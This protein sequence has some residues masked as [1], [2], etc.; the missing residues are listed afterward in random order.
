MHSSPISA[1]GSAS[2]LDI[3]RRNL[4]A[5]AACAAALAAPEAYA[6]TS[7]NAVYLLVHGAWHG[8]W[9]WKKIVPLLRA[10]GHEVYTPTLT[11]L[12]ERSHLAHRDVGLE[13]HIL[14]IVN[15]LQ[16]EDLREVILVGH[17]SGGIVI[18]GVA[19]RVPERL[20]HVVYLDAFVPEDGQALMDIIPADRR[21]GIERRVQAEGGGWQLPSLSPTPWDTFL[22]DAWAIDN[23]ADRQWMLPRLRPMPF[24]TFTDKVR[25]SNP[26][27]EKLPRSFIRC[28]QWP[29]P[30]FDRYADSAR[31]TAGWRYREI[32]AS[33][34]PFV[35]HPQDLAN[36]LLDIAG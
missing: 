13:T 26:V 11:G 36:V 16:Y 17:S 1:M 19:D 3:S 4:L 21:E 29:H 5:A 34:E 22:R 33:H 35:T 9:C 2:H 25:R 12:G 10:R 7:R 15:V 27:A 32:A 14:D 8:G 31:R 28:L 6:Q 20:A 23:E 24:N 18:T 30:A